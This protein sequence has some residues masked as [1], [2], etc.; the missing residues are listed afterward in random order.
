MLQE[1]ITNLETKMSSIEV[2][3]TKKNHDGLATLQQELK[4]TKDDA[5]HRSQTFDLTIHTLTANL[6]NSKEE[7]IELK[8]IAAEK[9]EV[10]K[11]LAQVE[12]QVEVLTVELEKSRQ[13]R[14]DISD[15]KYEEILS[16]IH[17][18]TSKQDEDK[19]LKATIITMKLKCDQLL[20]ERGTSQKKLKKLESLCDKLKDDSDKR[21]N[22]LQV[23]LGMYDDALKEIESARELYADLEKSS[24]AKENKLKENISCIQAEASSSKDAKADYFKLKSKYE[25]LEA[26]LDLI[27]QDSCGLKRNNNILQTEVRKLCLL[28]IYNHCLTN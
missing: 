13:S 2:V 14:G 1:T 19:D 10:D 20:E 8:K 25:A 6:E 7:V 5:R 16:A 12:A 23:T 26:E 9:I 27:R 18:N 22:E 11:K 24:T 15:A 17:S 4:E 21:R 3:D 28:L